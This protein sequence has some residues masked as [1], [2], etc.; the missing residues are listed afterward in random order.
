[1]SWIDKQVS[2]YT[3][4]RDNTGRPATYRQILLSEFGK[5]FPVIIALRDLQKK[6]DNQLIS[7]VDYK[8]KKAELKSKLQCFSPSALLQSRAKGNI[9]EI[10]RT[11]ILQLD[12]D[13]YDIQDYDIEELKLAVFSLPFIAFCGLSCSGKGFYALAL[14]AEPERLNDYAE[15]CFQVFLKYGIKAD[16][17]KGRN[18]N[19]LRY[20]SYDANMLIREEPE[21]LRIKKFKL[22]EAAKSVYQANYTKKTF[23]GNSAL[24]NAELQKI[25]FA[26]VGSRWE[27]VQ[28]V[29]YTLGGLNDFNFL[30]SIKQA[31]NNNS[32]FA[33]EES[34]YLKCADVCFKAGLQ[35]PI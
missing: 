15:N 7:D 10:S 1:M 22:Q 9:I 31:I 26:A 4:H 19:D 14:I 5:D 24:V 21:T 6:Y 16:T 28:K 35:K 32:S 29:S 11:G 8:I 2:L 18:V 33:G 12:F 17:S 30:E 27:T 3:S 34:K 25:Q 23:S 20:L 13:Y